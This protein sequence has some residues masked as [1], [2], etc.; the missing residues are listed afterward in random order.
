[1]SSLLA[2]LANVILVASAL[3]FGSQL[4]R[5]YPKTFSM[6]DR[7]SISLLG[8]LGILGT[9][10]FCVGQIWFSRL[11]ILL[12]LFLGV[13][14][15]C[16]SLARAGR[17]RWPTLESFRPTILPATV[18]VIIF[19][20]TGVGGLAR[21]HSDMNNDSIAYHYLGPKVWVREGVIRPVP[22][23]ITTYFPV[24][25]ETNYAAL[26]SVGGER[27]PGFF[28]V[29]SLAALLLVSA[30][31]AMRMGL[32]AA[33]AWWVA[34]LIATMPAIYEGT[35]GGFL[36]GMFA[37]FVLAAARIAFDAELPG[38]Y[39]L[40]G[41]FCGLGMATKYTG[42][43][44]WPILIFCSLVAAI[45]TYHR[46]LVASLGSMTIACGV[47]IAIASPF[48]LRNWILFGCPIYPPPPLLFHF[49]TPKPLAPAVIPALV[50]EVVSTGGGMGKGPL[51]FFLL[52][53]HMTYHAANF[54]GGGGIGLVPL[55]LGPFGV[56][57]RRFDPFAKGILLFAVLESAAWFVTAQVSRYAIV[58]YLI[59]AVFGVLGWQ[60]ITR[61]LSWNAR[62]LSAVAVAISVL[63]GMII[64]IPFKAEE[65]HAALSSSYEVRWR[66]ATTICSDAFDYINGEPSVRKILILDRGTAPFFIDKPYIKPFGIWGEQTI[67]GATNAAEVMA[68]LPSLHA[69]HVFDRRQEDGSFCLPEHPSGLTVV[70]ER[71]DYRIYRVN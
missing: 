56:V 61:K 22:D 35:V 9:I 19:F 4:Q 25:V 24:V 27:A 45:W 46:P 51:S 63:Y 64:I 32:D 13:L 37:G 30:A 50:E 68:Q 18:L 40:L 62:A 29:V 16:I 48:Y 23:E 36:D 71:Q 55:A 70:F 12:V 8:G 57:A 3:G 54:R 58:V 47:A 69:T 5:W 44:A 26:M 15:G 31:L 2:I 38:N 7:F 65:V 10:L 1:M 60:Y 34:A 11:A 41:I 52:P 66:M 6:L 67:P 33:G 39:A 17:V 42:I 14:F 28:A 59:A 21:P 20:V 49:F 53:F 43:V